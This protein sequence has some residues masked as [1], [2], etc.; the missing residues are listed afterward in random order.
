M[1]EAVEGIHDDVV[2]DYDHAD[3]AHAARLLVRGLEVQTVE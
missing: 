1:N 3:A 2:A